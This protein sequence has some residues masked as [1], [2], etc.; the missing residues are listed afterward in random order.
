MNL[1]V[2]SKIHLRE[3]G[4]TDIPDLIDVEKS[5]SG[6]KLY[7]PLLEE[8]EWKEELQKSVV[9][10]IEKESKIVGDVSYE[11]K[12]DN[13]IYISGLAINPRFQR[14]GIAREVLKQILE[15]FRDVKRID[16]VTH[17]DN[18]ALKLY[19]SFGFV[20]ESRKENYF[21]DGE[22]RLILVSEN[23]K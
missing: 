4:L 18:P 6:T 3:A 7:S 20:V 12:S 5:V 9:Y 17:P 21:G 15:K 1:A 19:Q 8:G 23:K 13:H 16:L 10:L 11:K 22:P 2:N 14:Q